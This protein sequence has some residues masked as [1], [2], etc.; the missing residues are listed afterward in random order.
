VKKENTFKTTK[1]FDKDFKKIKKI[2]QDEN[3]SEEY[4]EEAY[5]DFH[6]TY[7]SFDSTRLDGYW[8]KTK[9]GLIR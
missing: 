3:L 9:E 1:N 6:Q 8:R 2:L 4:K 7:Q 5:N